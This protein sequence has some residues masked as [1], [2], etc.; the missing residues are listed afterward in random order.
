MYTLSTCAFAR[1]CLVCPSL[2]ALCNTPFWGAVLCAKKAIGCDKT[3]IK[4]R[5]GAKP[6]HLVRSNGQV[7]AVR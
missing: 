6:G 7:V 1:F 2:V 5:L 4:V 3:L